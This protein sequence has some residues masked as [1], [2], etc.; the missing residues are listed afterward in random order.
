VTLQQNTISIGCQGTGEEGSNGLAGGG[1]DVVGNVIVDNNGNV[2]ATLPE[3]GTLL[4]FGFGLLGLVVSRKR[5]FPV[6]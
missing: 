6:A 4:L 5:L 2:V 1:L 3:P